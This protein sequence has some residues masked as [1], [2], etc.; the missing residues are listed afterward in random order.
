MST[1]PAV[2]TLS[3]DEARS[4]TDEVKHD[5]ERLWRKLVELYEGGAHEVLDYDSWGAYFK[6]EFGGS[7][8]KAYQL[9]SSGQIVKELERG[10]VSDLK[11]PANHEQAREL[12]PLLKQPE[13]LREAWAEVT[14]LHS[15]PTAKDVRE[16][17][18]RKMDVHYSSS[19]DLW[20]TPQ[21]LYDELHRE[22]AFTLDVCATPEN[23]KCREFFTE[24]TDGLAQEWRG[25]CWMN[26]P[27]GDAISAWVRKA[28]ETSLLGTVVV[29]L[30]PARVDT[31]WWWDY[32]RHGEVRILR[33]RLKFGDGANSAPF[34]SAVVVFG[35]PADTIYWERAA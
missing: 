22:F 10:A 13:V 1:L 2:A 17:V 18:S 35:R 31:A 14:E 4:L 33:G 24:A 30:V 26:P 27:Y 19:T 29:C 34:P 32:C 9:L 8:S 7:K 25:V 16:V 12:R 5:A 20:A 28:Y 6:A 15:E 11:L 3:R 23:A 21:K